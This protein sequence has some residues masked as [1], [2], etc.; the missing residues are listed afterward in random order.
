MGLFRKT[1]EE[2]FDK[3]ASASSGKKML[4]LAEDGMQKAMVN[5]AYRYHNGFGFKANDKSALFWANK[6]SDENLFGKTTDTIEAYYTKGNILRDLGDI[7]AAEESYKKAYDTGK[8]IEKASYYQEC[9]G[10]ALAYLYIENNK[11]YEEAKSI[12]I[13]L[14]AQKNQIAQWELAK[15]L[16]NK[17]NNIIYALESYVDIR[18]NRNIE[19]FDDIIF[20]TEDIINEFI[21]KM[22]ETSPD[23]ISLKNI[24]EFEALEK[25]FSE[26]EWDEL[27]VDQV[28]A[29]KN[30]LC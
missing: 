17:E 5:V 8:E 22:S 23:E 9:A 3:A 18:D 25:F 2:K 29:L 20:D 6:A 12:L 10:L 7:S 13:E 11:N 30:K 4:K 1:P 14:A 21:S 19:V 28:K 27:I 24:E 16:Y 26:V 15:L